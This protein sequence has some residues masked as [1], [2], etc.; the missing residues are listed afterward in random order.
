MA[1]RDG[2]DQC[3]F[4]LQEPGNCS[5][6]QPASKLLMIYVLP[7]SLQRKCISH[8]LHSQACAR[9]SL[10]SCWES[11]QQAVSSSDW[12]DCG[13]SM[14]FRLRRKPNNV[15]ICLKRASF[16]NMDISLNVKS[17]TQDLNLRAMSYEEEQQTY[18]RT[19]RIPSQGKKRQSL[20]PSGDKRKSFQMR[21]TIYWKKGFA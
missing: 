18:L 7:K 13:F 11:R 21:M 4:Y 12:H 16:P 15:Q 20:L 6:S 9:E 3:H 5:T 10:D 1:S 2:A 17:V 14:P 8:K 19:W